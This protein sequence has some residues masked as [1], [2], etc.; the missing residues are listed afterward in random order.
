MLEIM[1]WVGETVV[2]PIIVSVICFNIQARKTLKTEKKNMLPQMAIIKLMGKRKTELNKKC[3]KEGG[4]I[5]EISYE[6]YEKIDD[7]S[8][9]HRA[10]IGFNIIS[11][12]EILNRVDKE[13]LYWM[14]FDNV[15][16]RSFS[17]KYIIDKNGKYDEVAE[18]IVPVFMSETEK[19]SF[20]CKERDLPRTITGIF[21]GMPI[22]YN[23]DGKSDD[24]VLPKIKKYT[25]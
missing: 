1:K 20:V 19:Y 14:G 21:E 25:D 5:V 10:T 15:Q 11:Y 6:N 9:E 2:I 8:L 23:I 7:V 4:K 24:T 12:E 16:G 3:I 22:S 13:T 18:D 17:L